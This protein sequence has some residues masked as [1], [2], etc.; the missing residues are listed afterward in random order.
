MDTTLGYDSI[1]SITDDGE[2]HIQLNL[3][4][5]ATEMVDRIDF[6][7]AMVDSA[8]FSAIMVDETNF[9][10]GMVDGTDFFC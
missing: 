7:I 3:L 1:D 2:G 5:L 6:S 4:A 8:N 10:I 9:S